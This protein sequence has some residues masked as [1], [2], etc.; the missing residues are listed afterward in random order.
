M[1]GGGFDDEAGRAEAALQGVVRHERLL[2]RMQL[3]R[4]DALDR[5]HGF[6]GGGMRGHQ[7]ARHR[8]AVEQ[9]GAGAADAGAADELGAGE[10]AVADHVDQERIRIVR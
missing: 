3:A 1:E 4:C 10:A 7:T 2:H 6:S 8:R 5:G 9:H